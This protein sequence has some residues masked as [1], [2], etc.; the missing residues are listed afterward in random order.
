MIVRCALRNLTL[1]SQCH[2][3]DG[4]DVLHFCV[5]ILWYFDVWYF[6]AWCEINLSTVRLQWSCISLLL[7]DIEF[8]SCIY[9]YI[10]I[11]TYIIYIIYISLADTTAVP[12]VTWRPASWANASAGGQKQTIGSGHAM[13]TSEL[14]DV[15][16]II[17]R[18]PTPIDS[19][20]CWL[21]QM[22]IFVI[23]HKSKISYVWKV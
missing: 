17:T 20:Q 18:S 5:F 21:I 23:F 8:M 10:Y 13:M 1:L 22:W 12:G 14:C 19:W 2:L 9:I 7:W 15:M 4:L 16:R 3:T 6:S 11:Y